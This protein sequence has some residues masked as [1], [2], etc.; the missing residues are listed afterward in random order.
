MDTNAPPDG[1]AAP[2]PRG[3]T[4]LY[5][6]A[7]GLSVTPPDPGHGPDE[8]AEAANDVRGDEVDAAALREE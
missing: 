6:T 2:R 4:T 1:S 5:L 8:P 7:T 3:D